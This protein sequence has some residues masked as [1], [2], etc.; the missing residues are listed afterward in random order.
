MLNCFVAQNRVTIVALRS[1]FL[2][3]RFSP[4][5][6]PTELVAIMGVFGEVAGE[7]LFAKRS[8]P[9]AFSN[10][11][12]I[13]AWF[14]SHRVESELKRPLVFFLVFRKNVENACEDQFCIYLV[15]QDLGHRSQSD[16]IAEYGF[17]EIIH[18]HLL[19]R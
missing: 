18:G 3:M 17:A 14:R 13:Y 6:R 8:S 2:A 12:R 5:P 7:G 9:A 19:G 15:F 4:G 16:G 10:A 1:P 11:L